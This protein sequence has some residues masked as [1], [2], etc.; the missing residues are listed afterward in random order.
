MKG[1]MRRIGA[2][3][4]LSLLELWRRNDMFAL[5]VLAL[6]L[7]VPLSLARPFGASGATRYFDEAALLLV[8][9]YSLFISL[10]IGGRLFTSEFANRTVYP[11]LAKPVSRGELLVGKYL[12]AVAASWSALAFFYVLWAVSSLLRGGECLTVCFFQA[13]FLH[14]LFMALA[15]AAAVAG[16]FLLSPSA[17]TTLLA[18]LFPAMFFFGRRLPEY[19]ENVSGV[20]KGLVYAVYWV[21]PHA[22]FFDMRQRLVHGWGG[23]D[24][25]V[26]DLPVA[27]DLVTKYEGFV[28][29][30]E[31][32]GNEQYGILYRAGDEEI[33]KKMDEAVMQLVADGTYLQLVEKYNL[34]KEYFALLQAAE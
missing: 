34:E 10:G 14:A 23:V 30:D 28:I 9:G 22:E 16:S 4:K 17:S 26:V 19:A 33:C 24:A 11:L 3:V 1:W 2:L 12:G 15:V 32:L 18:I 7:L 29:L 25:V 31:I 5:L 20:L 27:Q 21:A 8:W 13:F 6:V